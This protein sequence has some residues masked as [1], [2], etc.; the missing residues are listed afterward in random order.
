[1]KKSEII[2]EVAK[3]SWDTTVT[4]GELAKKLSLN[5]AWHAAQFVGLAW[6][7]FARR[8]DCYTCSAISRVYRPKNG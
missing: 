7:Y 8:G 1:M 6:R 5:S 3:A 2:G 4:F